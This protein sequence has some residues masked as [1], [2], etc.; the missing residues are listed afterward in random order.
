VYVR[1][2]QSAVPLRTAIGSTLSMYRLCAKPPCNR[3]A[4]HALS[5]E[6]HRIT[7]AIS[8][9][10]EALLHFSFTSGPLIFQFAQRSPSKLYQR[11]VPSLGMKNSLRHFTN[12]S[13][14]FY[15]GE[16][17]RHL[18]SIFDCSRPLPLVSNAAIFRKSITS[19]GV[20]MIGRC[21]SLI[22]CSSLH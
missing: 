5:L 9:I 11:Y 7:N 18:A 16:N 14:N 8:T 1:R 22:L 15:T 12:P 21:S 19:L 4:E 2:S 3:P 13:T 6:L 10:V 17:V 20:P